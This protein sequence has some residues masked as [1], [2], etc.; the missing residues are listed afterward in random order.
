MGLTVDWV[1]ATIRIGDNHKKYGDD[2][3]TVV[4]VMKIGSDMAYL[5][6][7]SGAIPVS[8]YK[9]IMA[10]LRDLGFKHMKYD[11]LHKTV[12]V[13]LYRGRKRDG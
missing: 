7:A 8:V 13:D 11:R 2:F 6:G 5:Y 9:E 4:S 10:E 3:E 12:V 1:V